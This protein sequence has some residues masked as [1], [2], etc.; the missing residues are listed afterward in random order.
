M[1]GIKAVELPGPCKS[2]EPMAS[3]LQNSCLLAE[4]Q[5]RCFAFP[6]W[7]LKT[8]QNWKLFSI[9]DIQA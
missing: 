7:K 2:L 9:K 6:G 8:H 3:M 4:L 1:T 5:T